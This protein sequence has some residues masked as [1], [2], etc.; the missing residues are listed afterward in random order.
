MNPIVNNF[1]KE[2]VASNE[3]ILLA[4]SK[5]YDN[6]DPDDPKH[7][8]DHMLDVMDVAKKIRGR[9]LDPDEFGMIAFHDSGYKHPKGYAYSKSRH[10]MFGAKIFRKEGPKL[11]YSP[12]EV[13][14]IA[15]VIAYH[16]HRPDYASSPL[17]KDDMQMLLFSADEGT[18]IDLK[19]DAKMYYVKGR[20]GVYKGVDPNSKDFIKQL[21][22]KVKTFGN[23]SKLKRLKYYNDVYPGYLQSKYDFWQSPDLEKYYKELDKKDK[24]KED[25]YSIHGAILGCLG[26]N[27]KKFKYN[28][29]EDLPD[30]PWGA[31]INTKPMT[32]DKVRQF[33]SYHNIDV[34]GAGVP[35]YFLTKNERTGDKYVW[36]SDDEEPIRINTKE[37]KELAKKIGLKKGLVPDQLDF[38]FTEKKAEFDLPDL[39]TNPRNKITRLIKN[40]KWGVRID[41]KPDSPDERLFNPDPK[42]KYEVIGD[43]SSNL[44]SCV[45]LTNRVV[46]NTKGVGSLAT[47]TNFGEIPHLTPMFKHKGKYY[48]IHGEHQ[49][50]KPYDKLEDVGERW[51]T[52]PT[53]LPVPEYIDF[54]DLPAGETIEEKDLRKIINEVKKKSKN[55]YR[56]SYTHRPGYKKKEASVDISDIVNAYKDQYGFDLSHMKGKHSKK[57]RYNNGKIAKDIPV[58][59]YGGS[60]AKNN[61]IYLNPDMD[62]VAKYYGIDNTD[63]LRKTIVAHELAHEIYN[64]QAT[65]EYIKSIV[66][67]AKKKKFTTAY[68]KTV[69][70]RKIDEETFCEYLANGL[71]K[72]A[73]KLYTYV[74]PDADLS[75]GLLSVKLAPE[76]VLLRRYSAIV[77]DLKDKNKDAIIKHFEDP[78]YGPR[79]T[80][81]IF[82]L[83]APIPD[84]ANEGLLRF[85]DKNKLVS[86]DPEQVKDLISVVRRR[87]SP[88]RLEEV[89]AN[90]EPLKHVQWGRKPKDSNKAFLYAPAYKVLTESGKI[91]PEL[92][93]IES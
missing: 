81:L 13:K 35:Y 43:D 30:D 20:N 22:A 27:A 75:K 16:N 21:V 86:W 51:Y 46:K 92:L 90:F 7:R 62:A 38:K 65:K 69:P 37:E 82:A 17:L 18:P 89:P 1:I 85:R 29:T 28:I 91:P 23:Y 8:W 31:I 87:H 50:S 11:G 57:P 12:E 68:L 44:A 3:D 40:L 24:K 19:D 59:S 45:D 67:E 61:T 53:A 48:I 39:K 76:D 10:P 2:A 74:D 63:D 25:K 6:N 60:W 55:T 72:K 14:R 15:K 34:D 36:Y 32:M 73:S 77:K 56:K 78:G 88:K 41:G 66:D 83:D 42:K 54:Y 9:D 71:S 5:Y 93:T 58:E 64:K 26:D 52:D 49:Y 70:D 84:N 4:A 47:L 79:R 80:D 33:H